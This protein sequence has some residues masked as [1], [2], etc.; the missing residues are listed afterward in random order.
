MRLL[1]VTDFNLE[2]VY[3]LFQFVLRFQHMRSSGGKLQGR[4]QPGHGMEKKRHTKSLDRL[5]PA[6]IHMNRVKKQEER[7]GVHDPFSQPP[8]DMR[9]RSS[10][11]RS[12]VGDGLSPWSRKGPVSGKEMRHATNWKLLESLVDSTTTCIL[13]E[14]FSKRNTKG[15]TSSS[16]ARSQ[17][18]VEMAEKR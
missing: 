9:K 13:S 11:K 10:R 14:E 1:K 8:G 4:L 17:N 3:F 18:I 5:Q 16:V 15:L 7:H 12:S 2:F 6:Y